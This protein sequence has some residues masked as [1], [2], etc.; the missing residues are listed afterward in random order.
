MG[1]E[2]RGEGL[3]TAVTVSKK[4]M[5]L[6]LLRDRSTAIRRRCTISGCLGDEGRAPLE[7]F[8]LVGEVGDIG[9]E[10]ASSHRIADKASGDEPFGSD[11][12]RINV[13][14][15]GGQS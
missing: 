6:V 9:G 14:A 10:G 8:A 12:R 5:I 15:L 1:G 13:L 11:L 2:D 4:L 3:G 7:S